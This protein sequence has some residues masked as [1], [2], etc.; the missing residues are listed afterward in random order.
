LTTLGNVTS[1]NYRGWRKAPEE[2]TLTFEDIQISYLFG[3]Y[4]PA[5]GG[6]VP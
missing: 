2:I 5:S 3:K 4:S 1:Q 6:S